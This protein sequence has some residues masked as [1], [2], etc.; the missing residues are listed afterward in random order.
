MIYKYSCV[1]LKWQQNDSFI[2]IICDIFPIFSLMLLQDIEYSF[3][4]YSTNSY[5]LSILCIGIC[6][7]FLFSNFYQQI[8]VTSVAVKSVGLLKTYLR[9]LWWGSRH[10]VVQWQWYHQQSPENVF[11]TIRTWF[12]LSPLALD[13]DLFCELLKSLPIKIF[14][15]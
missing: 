12:H 14:F 15:W 11:L 10:G 1:S 3:L 6:I 5:C 8:S 4:C 2:Y 7:G 13:Q 9:W